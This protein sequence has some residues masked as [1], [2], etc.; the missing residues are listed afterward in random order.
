MS[1]T[2][3]TFRLKN[4]LSLKIKNEWVSLNQVW[5]SSSPSSPEIRFSD[6][7]GQTFD[8]GYFIG[9]Y[10][11][12]S[13]SSIIDKTTYSS[14]TTARVPGANVN[15]SD[16]CQRLSA[17]GNSAAGYFG[18]GIPGPRSTVDKVTYA[19]DTT[20]EVPGAALSVARDELTAT[21]ARVNDAPSS[22]INMLI[23]NIV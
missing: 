22:P 9:G 5:I 14:D 17:T 20:A 1:G 6:G 8:N 18:G 12:S 21:S 23:E 19:S 16:G 11:G 3:G 4:V 2:R 10:T 15:T 13:P 7:A